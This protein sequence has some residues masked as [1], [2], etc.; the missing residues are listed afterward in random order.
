MTN[1]KRGRDAGLKASSTRSPVRP[2]GATATIPFGCCCTT[3]PIAGPSAER[4]LQQ[5]DCGLRRI[6]EAAR[7]GVDYIQLREKD[8]APRDLECLAREAVRAVR[9]NSEVSQA[10][11]Q[12]PHRCCAG[13][14]CRWRSPGIGRVGCVGDSGA[15][16]QVQRSRADHR[17][18]CALVSGCAARQI[19]RRG[20]RGAGADLR[21]GAD[22]RERNWLGCT[23]RSVFGNTREFSGRAF[24]RIGAGRSESHEC[25]RLSSG[26]RRRSRRN[27]AVSKR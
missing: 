9:D 26:R 17:R 15:M 21:E 18:V 12:Q 8:L 24:R 10:I 25:S 3:S 27:P 7:A 23:A 4:R 14:R 2:D 11:D 20:L 6:A 1:I 13:L 16:E 19:R 5:R 22:W